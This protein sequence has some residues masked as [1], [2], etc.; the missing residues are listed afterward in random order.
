MEGKKKY[1]TLV[2]VSRVWEEDGLKE[3]VVLW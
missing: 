1:I 2:S 3:N